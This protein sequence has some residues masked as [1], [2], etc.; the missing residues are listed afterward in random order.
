MTII[1]I[2]GAAH[3][4]SANLPANYGLEVMRRVQRERRCFASRP[5]NPARG[6]IRLSVP[7]SGVEVGPGPGSDN[8]VTVMLSSRMK[9]GS[10]RA[11]NFNSVLVPPAIKL[12]I[13]RWAQVVDF[14]GKAVHGDTIKIGF[15]NRVRCSAVKNTELQLVSGAGDSVQRLTD[16]G[17]T[18]GSS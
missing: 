7:G 13:V 1:L 2:L 18:S 8:N 17:E 5:I 12:P 9:L 15:E 10:L 3:V 14:I 6:N 16:V 11:P 4:E